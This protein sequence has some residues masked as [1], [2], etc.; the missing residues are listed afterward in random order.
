MTSHFM[1]PTNMTI[2][3]S[4]VCLV[5]VSMSAPADAQN[6]VIQLWPKGLPAGSQKLD[7]A[8]NQIPQ[9]AANQGK[10]FRRRIALPNHLSGT[11]GK[12]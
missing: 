5:G 3:L 2:L 11:T 1:L 8:K 4:T 6:L 9:G 7:A 12:G 10:N